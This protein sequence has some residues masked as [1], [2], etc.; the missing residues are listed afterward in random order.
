MGYNRGDSFPFDFEPNG[1]PF[2]S[3]S[4]GKLSPRSYSYPIQSERKCKNS[5]LSVSELHFPT[6]ACV[7]KGP[8]EQYRSNIIRVNGLF[9]N[10]IFNASTK[11]TNH[12]VNNLLIQVS[13][14][15]SLLFSLI[16]HLFTLNL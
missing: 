13:R 16:I 3:K 10:L 9:W 2:G 6:I 8:Y 12:S 7:M 5:F 11:N 14:I 4:K 1:I 15:I